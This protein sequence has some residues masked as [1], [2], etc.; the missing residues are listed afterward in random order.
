MF[1]QQSSGT[2]LFGHV[3]WHL[4]IYYKTRFWWN[5]IHSLSAHIVSTLKQIYSL[6]REHRIHAFGV[7]VNSSRIL[8]FLSFFRVS[9]KMAF[10]TTGSWTTPSRSSLPFSSYAISCI[11]CGFVLRLCRRWRLLAFASLSSLRENGGFYCT[12]SVSVD[13]FFFPRPGIE[14]PPKASGR[15]HGFNLTPARDCIEY[16]ESWHSAHFEFVPFRTSV[17]D[18]Y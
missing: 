5:C 3:L 12:S 10:E 1:E 7:R 16:S 6:I 18:H 9:R 13:S 2:H 15:A 4:A 8:K 14:I 17:S 11:I